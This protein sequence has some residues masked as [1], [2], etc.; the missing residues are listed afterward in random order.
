MN[1]PKLSSDLLFSVDS[2][3]K[4][5]EEVI[6]RTRLDRDGILK[7]GNLSV[8][9]L[10]DFGKTHYMGACVDPVFLAMYALS[11]N[12]VNGNY[13]SNLVLEILLH[14]PKTEAVKQDKY[15]NPQP[16]VALE[17]LFENEVYS[18][19]FASR[20]LV[21]LKKGYYSTNQPDQVTS[22]NVHRINGLNFDKSFIENI[23]PKAHALGVPFDAN[24]YLHILADLN[25]EP[26]GSVNF[27]RFKN[28]VGGK[29]KYELNYNSLSN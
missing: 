3:V 8:S 11:Q 9:Q 16:H 27:E 18:L 6:P 10:H 29:I 28:E 17:F 24:R 14:K 7:M 25:E 12:A 4:W 22:L 15:N 21:V 5:V 23:S 26:H 19:D 20:N 1:V 13:K 2:V